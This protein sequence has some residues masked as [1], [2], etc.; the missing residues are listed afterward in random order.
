MKSLPLI[1]ATLSLGTLGAAATDID[2]T[3]NT[4]NEDYKAYGFDKRETYDVAIKLQDP[5]YIGAKVTGI[6]VGV[7][8]LDPAIENVSAWMS[9]ELK[10]ENKL[11]APDI[12]SKA[13]TV[14]DEVLNVTFDEPY[15]I[16]ADG[17]WIGYSLTITDLSKDYNWPGSPVAVIESEE[18]LD[19]GLWIH[20]SR[21]RLQ[22][23]NLGSSLSAVS[24]MV[25]H[26]STG[27]GP[28]DVALTLPADSYIVR[29]EQMG[30]PMT[31]INHGSEP[32]EELTYSYSIG[33]F[34]GSGTYHLD[35]PLGALGKPASVELPV[36]P[37][38]TLGEFPFKVSLETSNGKPNNDPYRRGE[39]QMNVWPV[40]PVTRP[41][42]EE[43]TGLNC[44]YCPRG[45]VAMEEM[46]KQYGDMFVGLAY[47]T[48][49]Y[50]TAMVTVKDMD[51]PVYVDG[52]PKGSV[53]RETV[54]DPANLAYLWPKA[55]TQIVP[56][57]VDVT[58]DWANG[59]TEIKAR[60]KV[61]F[62]KDMTDANYKLSF[63]LVAD[64]LQNE[65]WKQKNYYSGKKKGDGIE[66]DL[67][68][69]FL[70][71]GS[72]I[73]GLVYNDVVAYY[74]DIMGIDG[75][76][77]AN[78]KAGEPIEYEY[79]FPMDQ[80][81]TVSKKQFLNEGCTLHAV[82]I[83]VDAETGYSVNCNKSADLKYEPSGVQS[84]ANDGAQVVKVEYRNLQGIRIAAPEDGI[85][86][87]TEIMSDGTR[88]T[89]KV[90]GR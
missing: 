85:Y 47:H 51:F 58:A 6:T 44:G 41:L 72:S 10:I 89:V 70:N 68:D 50:E 13:G 38:A 35:T 7:P 76:I 43:Y 26:L 54:T 17:V 31:L 20:S 30:V 16:T 3:Y 83:V 42:V 66:S 79:T 64:G 45:Y 71:G 63:A 39:G 67:W 21:S 57:S 77:P 49:S 80:V 23:V 34:T 75:S 84:V 86:I 88:R 25:V 90:A 33:D 8:V 73:S 59:G 9:S 1:A 81:L 37:V 5:A 65:S 27:F 69:I 2:F 28:N 61:T 19:K 18:N 22:W 78:V 40:I 24:T 36:G 55:A 60:G 56:M 62:V 53:N 15:T 74:K 12:T 87:R 48:Q 52:Y 11:N 29:N 82:A 46:N 32:L 14:T 4:N